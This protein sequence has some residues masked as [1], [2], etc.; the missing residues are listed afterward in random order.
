[1]AV[2]STVAQPKHFRRS[3]LWLALV[4]SPVV[5][6]EPVALETIQVTAER[7]AEAD[8][9]V[10]A[11]SIERFLSA[12]LEDIF[13]GEPEVSVGSSVGVA[14]KVYVRGLED[15]LLNVSVDGATQAGVLFHHTGRI[16]VD[17]DLLKRVEVDTG[18][19]KASAGAGALGGAIRFITKDPEDLLREGENVGALVKLG[20]FSNTKGYSASTTIFGRLNDQWSTLVSVN[21]S[22]HERYEDGNGDE[23]PGTDA[24]Q[25]VGM[26]KLVGHFANGQ[27]LRLSHEIRNDEGERPQR[28]QWAV[29]SFNKL[30][31]LDGRRDT[32]TLNYGVA[33]EGNPWLDAEFTLYQSK[34]ELEQNVADR[35]GRYFGFT[36]SIGGDLRNTSQ[37]GS[38]SLTYGVDYR[39]DKVNA[40]GEADKRAEE[41]TGDVLGVYLQ[42]DVWLTQQ[43]LLSAGA[44]YDD[45]NLQDNNDQTFSEDAVS[46][47]ASL[48]WQVL[49][50][51]T[52]KAGYAEAFRGPM[53]RDAFKVDL[54]QNDPDLKGE[55]AKNTEVGFDY[56]YQNFSL[57]AEVYRSEIKD[58]IAD[59]LFGPAIYRNIGDLKS[60]GYRIAT[61]YQWNALSAGLSFHSNDAEVDGQPLTVYE[62]N[63]LGNTIGDTWVAD[64]TYLW[65]H[66]LEFGW[67]GQFVQGIDDLE[68]TV[69]TIDKPGYGVHDLF[70]NW[71]PTGNEDL[72]LTLAVKNVGDKQYLDHASN[73]DYQ[74]IAGYEG[75][76]GMPAPG[77]DIRLGL[78]M[79]F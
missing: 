21:Q 73:A 28:P 65:S 4:S 49:N 72:R 62:H 27:T 60:D 57:S 38:H 52:L 40:G 30:Y 23:V 46:P 67:Q 61:G 59:V 71:L 3:A 2:F 54:A 25:Q 44:R 74:G 33:P 5:Y 24:R 17:P 6:A 35:W 63:L 11:K 75:V 69:G 16:A 77:R 13:A 47:N 36:R 58:A 34:A 15:P 18:A 42:A 66:N 68:T 53:P 19:G 20:S 39:E 9:V 50:G 7:E 10:D 45:Y 31:D 64:L 32:T 48:A 79:R 56:V 8:A 78:A 26:A 76:V 1:M 55:K 14:Q 22:D 37:L 29:S 41:E 70:V 12:D 51:L 43:L